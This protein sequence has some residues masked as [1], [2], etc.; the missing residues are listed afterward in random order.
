MPSLIRPPAGEF[1]SDA[2]VALE[3]RP[4]IVQMRGLIGADGLPSGL[5]VSSAT[6]PKLATGV[7]TA[8]RQMR[9]EPARLR[10]VPVDTSMTMEIRF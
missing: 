9:W 7:L 8:V 2:I 6:S 4:G 1:A 10:G 5:I 3:G